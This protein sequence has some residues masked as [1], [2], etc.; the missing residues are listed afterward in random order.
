M[1]TYNRDRHLHGVEEYEEQVHQSTGRDFTVGL[2]IGLIVGTVGG[3]LLA[4]KS[5]DALRDDISEQ[6]QKF[7]EGLNTET[8]EGQG[9]LKDKAQEKKEELSN[10]VN[11]TKDEMKAKKGEQ[12]EKQRVKSLDESAVKAQ[13]D[14]IQEEVQEPGRDD[15]RTVDVS[16]FEETLDGDK[17]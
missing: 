12:E 3:L 7:S 6:T 8:G 17:K 11:E 4:P 15:V 9:S 13:K 10:K 2:A 16:K 5:G 14:A 1:E